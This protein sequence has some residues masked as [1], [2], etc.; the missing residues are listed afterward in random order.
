MGIFQLWLNFQK[1][2][3]SF[4]G[5]YQRK[6]AANL[7]KLTVLDAH[8]VIPGL[9]TGLESGST[10]IKSPVQFAEGGQSGRSHPH[11]QIL[12]LKSIVGLIFSI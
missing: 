1:I 11:D 3:G 7:Y 4:A 2:I 9:K 10:A 5:P 6:C 12:V 8:S